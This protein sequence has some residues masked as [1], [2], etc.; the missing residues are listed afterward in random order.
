VRVILDT[1]LF[2]SALLT[3]GTPPQE[4]CEH[5]RQGRF[6]LVSCEPQLKELRAVLGRPFFQERIKR[7]QAGSMVNDVRRLALMYEP[8]PAPVSTD[9]DDDYPL[10]LA[11]VSRADFLATG[12]KGHLLGLGHHGSA[13]ILTA[14]DLVALLGM[15]GV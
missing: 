9:P 2:V 4:L 12:D 14:G 6:T 1:N 10:A 13:R 5:W 7:S 11:A 8:T 3:E 15:P